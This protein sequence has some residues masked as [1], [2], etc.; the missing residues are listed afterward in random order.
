MENSFKSLLLD[1]CLY[2]CTDFEN[3]SCVME[4]VCMP[5]SSVVILLSLLTLLF[6]LIFGCHLFSKK[7]KLNKTPKQKRG[8]K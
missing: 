6:L 4:K 7:K 1:R 5:M 8:K 2:Q 3:G